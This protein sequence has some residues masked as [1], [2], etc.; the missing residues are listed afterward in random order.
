MALVI[1]MILL[2]YVKDSKFLVWILFVLFVVG[3]LMAN[4][5]A[6][7]AVVMN[8]FNRNRFHIACQEYFRT[9]RVL[10]PLKVNKQEPVLYTVRRFFRSIDL[11]CSLQKLDKLDQGNLI[12]FKME[13]FYIYFN[14]KSKILVILF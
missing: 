14:L 4:Y 8:T 1:N 2:S 7:K 11:G 3:H 6:V 9:G 13:K 12:R 10:S 5:N